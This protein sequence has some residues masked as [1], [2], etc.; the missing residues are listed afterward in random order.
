[1][2]IPGNSVKTIENDGSGAT[3][4]AQGAPPAATLRLAGSTTIGDELAP[5]LIEAFETANGAVTV[6]QRPAPSDSEIDIVGKRAGGGAIKVH[7]SRHGSATAFTALDGYTADIGM[8]S[9][10]ITQQE[11]AKLAADGLGDFTQPGL[12]NVVALDG[13]IVVVNKHNPVSALSLTQIHD[14]FTG[15]MT[16]W[17]QVG[18]TPGPIHLYGRDNK[19]GTGDTFKA[20]ALGG[21]T[22]VGTMTVAAS[23][24]DLAVKVAADPAG[25]GYTGFAYLGHNKALS[26]IT[27]CGMEFAPSDMLV[28]TEDYPLARRLYLYAEANPPNPEARPFIDFALG[29]QGQEIVRDN[30]FIDLIPRLAPVDFGRAQVSLD[31]VN[32]AGDNG[33]TS[34]DKADFLDYARHV[35]YGTRITTTFRFQS[36]SFAL[37]ARAVED[38]DRLVAFLKTPAVAGRHLLIAGFADSVGSSRANVALSLR[39]ADTIAT[40]LR[41]DGIEG[42][43]VTGYGQI[44]PVACNTDEN[45]REKNRRVEI[46]LY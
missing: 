14:L 28:R 6:T 17:S 42:A 12:E 18:G 3:A 29:P 44:A 41:R 36:G 8:A 43:A 37:D 9:R 2:T 34:Q 4:T 39:R 30:N 46:W 38:V 27:A 32:M 33:T 25:V 7:L 26:I 23:A 35:V 13:L 10:R 5:A 19:S 15:K 16:D 1:V 24:E 21:D 22:P 45:G 40:L 11:A 31:L 20:L